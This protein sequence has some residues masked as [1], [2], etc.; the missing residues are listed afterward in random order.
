MIINL[1]TGRPHVATI[2]VNAPSGTAVTCA[3]S[4]Y[5]MSGTVSG[6]S[7][8]FIA[9]KTG[10]WTIT[11]VK[12]GTTKT[13]TVSVSD[14]SAKSVTLTYEKYLFKAGTGEVVTFTKTLTTSSASYLSIGKVDEGEMG[15]ASIITASKVD[16]TNYSTL[17]IDCIG[18]LSSTSKIIT[19]GIGTAND[20]STFTKSVSISAEN[21]RR[22]ETLNISSN[23]G[24][25][26]VI[27][28]TGTI[29]GPS[30][31]LLRAYNIYLDT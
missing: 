26:Y 20:T 18:S 4:P 14:H 16:L 27:L 7:I 12:S 2:T 17:K 3:C 21:S 29:V 25:Y 5:S 13:A 1:V 19:F 15:L 11:G 22:T 8:S 24:N 28:K 30:S 31:W 10:T 23:T 9:P 6:S